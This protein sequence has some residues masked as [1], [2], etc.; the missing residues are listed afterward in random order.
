MSVFFISVKSE[1]GFNRSFGSRGSR[2]ISWE[3]CP[4]F[5]EGMVSLPHPFSLLAA[6]NE[7]VGANL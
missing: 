7:F 1:L 3:E 5:A 4:F 2:V 6:L